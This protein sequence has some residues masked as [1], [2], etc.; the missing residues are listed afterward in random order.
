MISY[1]PL[2]NCKIPTNLQIF[3]TNYLSVAK[4]VIPFQLLPAFI[5][6]PLAFLTDF[7]T[8]PFSYLYSYCGY[9]SLSFIYNF[10]S[11]L[12]T[13]L[14]LLI[15]YLIL[16]FLTWIAPRPKCEYIHKWKEE[17]EYNTILRS[18]IECYLDLSF[19]SIL[20]IWAVLLFL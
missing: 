10:A 13:W 20:N 6:N 12:F 9:Y 15:I 8:E 16:N 3:L 11:E 14:F 2:I 7:L 5:P 4:I 17:Y 18:I 19:C 1:L